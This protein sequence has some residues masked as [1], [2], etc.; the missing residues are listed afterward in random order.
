MTY[1]GIRSGM[2]AVY[3]GVEFKATPLQA[4]GTVLLRLFAE[5]NPDPKLFRRN[6]HLGIWQTQVPAAD[7]ER[8]YQATA[9][10]RYQGHRVNVNT[11]DG[12]GTA[13]V[14]YADTSY[15]WPEKNGF[16][17]IDKLVFLK[18]ASAWDLREVHEQQH[19]QLF[20]QWREATFARANS[21]QA[22]EQGRKAAAAGDFVRPR[23]GSFATL[24]RREYR[25][26]ISP[27]TGMVSLL[28]TTV[29]NP[30]PALFQRSERHDQ[31]RAQVHS[32]QCE[33]LDEVST[34]AQHLG[35]IC[36]VLAINCDGSV[37]LQCLWPHDAK[38]ARAGFTQSKTQ[39]NIWEKTTDI[40]ELRSLWENHTDLLF[41]RT[42]GGDQ[43]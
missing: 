9:Y 21:T 1:T 20:A 40:H 42:F 18:D 29:E 22:P 23:S 3:G 28:S 24:N 16:T 30:D 37:D 26:E 7:C 11:L 35:Q 19:D 32:E 17:Q 6:E 43:S 31:W 36:Q 10:A 25:A 12:S 39:P 15:G 14:Y 4:D 41:V 27:E 33:R 2:Y 8:I 5:D 13:Q 38:A 34:W